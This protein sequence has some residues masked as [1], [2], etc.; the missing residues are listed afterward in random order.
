MHLYLATKGIKKDVDDFINQLTGKWLP[1]KW[2]VKKEDKMEDTFIQ[3]SVRPIQLWEIGFPKDQKDIICTTILGMDGGKI[4]GND[5]VKPTE[6]KFFNWLTKKMST[7]FGLKPIG[8]YNTSQ[9]LPLHR[10]AVAV[11]GLGLKDD[12]M[13]ETGVEGI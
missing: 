12:Y 11:I 4:R 8:D 2:R 13:M 9:V 6:Y 3:L 7:L 1:F 5:G 10:G